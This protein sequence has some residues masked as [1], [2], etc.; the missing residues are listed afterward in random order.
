MF[1][2]GLRFN[3]T[4]YFNDIQYSNATFCPQSA[5][6]PQR[7]VFHLTPGITFGYNASYQL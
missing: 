4:H 7:T 6:L 5:I 3:K 1:Y 2:V